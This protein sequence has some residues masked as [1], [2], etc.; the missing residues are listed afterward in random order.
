M[1]RGKGQEGEY[2]WTTG[3]MPSTGEITE[4][5][6]ADF[7]GKACDFCDRYK[8]SGLSPS[9]KLLM[10]FFEEDGIS[11]KRILDLGCGAGAFA[12]ETLKRGAESVVGVDLSPEM[13]KTADRLALSNGLEAKAKFQLGNAATVELP[14]SDMVVLDKVICCYPEY[15]PLLKNAVG[16]TTAAVGF[17]V[18]RDAGLMKGPLRVGVRIVNFFQRR[19]K[20]TQFYL[21]PLGAIDR[22]LGESSFVRKRKQGSRFWLVFLYMRA[23]P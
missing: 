13:I 12:I 7:D 18:P 16:A 4:R 22:L 21:H 3:R 23:R 15:G 2:A 5:I 20:E 17:V 6:A 9:S 8:K 19:R 14:L 1:L 10:R 11:G